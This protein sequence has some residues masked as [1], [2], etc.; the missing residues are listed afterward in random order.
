MIGL[1]IFVIIISIIEINSMAKKHLRRE[2]VVYICLAF[3][4]LI[5]D[6]FFF[7]YPNKQSIAE[8]IMNFLKL[9]Y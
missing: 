4:T 1:A 3:A 8:I 9:Q 6:W 5:F 2:I 7:S